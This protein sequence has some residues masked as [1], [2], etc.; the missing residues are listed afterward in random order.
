MSCL[1]RRLHLVAARLV[2]DA[3]AATAI[4]YALIALL[5]A[6]V[7]AAALPAIPTKINATLTSISARL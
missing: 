5:I 7:I 2:K 4:E 6:G 1:V 3:A